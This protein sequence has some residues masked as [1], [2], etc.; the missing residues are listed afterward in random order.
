MGKPLSYYKARFERLV[1]S[2][3]ELIG[4]NEVDIHSLRMF[5]SPFVY[6][7]DK[8]ERLPERPS[9]GH[10]SV[11][12][13]VAELTE[14]VD[15]LWS[16]YMAGVSDG[17]AARDAEDADTFRR[18]VEDWKK[19]EARAGVEATRRVLADDAK[20]ADSLKKAILDD[21]RKFPEETE[22][23]I[24]K[25]RAELERRKRGRIDAIVQFLYEA[26]R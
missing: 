23:E 2:R 18:M 8:S 26:L 11:G 3:P 10:A 12:V 13:E 1:R 5:W 15:R 16:A 9:I 7:G 21:L 14:R 6:I 17:G 25:Q 20:R 24:R 19:R 4:S 22:T